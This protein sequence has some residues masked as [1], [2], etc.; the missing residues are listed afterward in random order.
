[1]VKVKA[2]HSIHAVDA[3]GETKIHNPGAEFSLS[4]R[5]AA[6]LVERGAVVLVTADVE[7]VKVEDDA[8]KKPADTKTEEIP[9]ETKQ[10]E[11]KPAE[12]KPVDTK[13]AEPAK[14]KGKGKGKGAAKA[15]AKD[16]VG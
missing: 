2:L 10:E 16:I 6:A 9:V 1:M 3:K 5:E 14:G 11:L 8:D 12:T 13:P 4:D 15:K 7:E